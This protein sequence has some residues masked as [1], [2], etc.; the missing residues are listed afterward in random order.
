LKDFEQKVAK[1]A[2]RKRQGEEIVFC[3]LRVLLF[4]LFA[5]RV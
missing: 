1:G 3:A 4:Q 5:L 2:K